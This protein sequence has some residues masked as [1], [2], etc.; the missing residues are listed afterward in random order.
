MIYREN[1]RWKLCPKKVKFVDKGEKKEEYTNKPLWYKN[2]EKRHGQ[3]RL[4]V[5]EITEAEYSQEE[6]NRLEKIEA[7]CEAKY[8]KKD[9]QEYNQNEE[10]KKEAHENRVK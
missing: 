3:E 4:E 10:K 1:G 6:K 2:F 8:I 9:V 7:D 5:S